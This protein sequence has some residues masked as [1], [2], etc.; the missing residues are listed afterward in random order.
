M[1]SELI[2]AVPAA[3]L[4]GVL[5]GWFWARVLLA[6][7]DLYERIAYSTALS[8]VLVPSVI[9]V[10]TRLF[11]A[12]VSLS[13]ALASPL[14]VF[15][16]GLLA[17]VRFGGA[18]AQQEPI[19]PSADPLRG[20]PAQVLLIAAFA[21]ALGVVIGVVPR[22]AIEP[23]VTVG[24]V[25]NM[26][27]LLAIALLVFFAGI[28]HLI[29]TLR[30]PAPRAEPLERPVESPSLPAVLAR[31]LLLPA[32]LVLALLRG[33][34]GPILHDWPFIR[35]VDHYSHAV[36]AELM[37]TEGRIEPYLIYP[38]GF[39][40]MTAIVCRLTGLEPLEVFPV[41]APLLLLLPALALYALARRVWGWEYGVVAA[42]FSVLMGGT[43]YYYNDAMYPNLVTS[44]FLLVL[45]VAAL[46]GLYTSPPSS[47]RAAV[48]LALLGSS[49]VLYHQVASMYLAALLAVVGVVFVP[50]LLLRDRGKGLA[51]FCALAALGSLSVLY[52][53]ETYDLPQAIAGLLGGS[54][55]GSTGAA[56]KM[57]VG[58]QEP[59]TLDFL[60][61]NMVSQPVAWLG[62]L[63]A[64]LVV[65]ELVRRD[66]AVET[67]QRLTY[68]T[69]LLLTL[70]LFV[71]SRLWLTG[72]PQRFGRDVCVPLAV[73]AAF[74]FVAILRSLPLSGGRVAT[75]FVASLAVI[76][77]CTM[78]GVRAMSSLEFA[79]APSVQ[80]TITPEISAA[81]EWLR[82]HNEGGNIMVS[83]HINQVPSRMMLAMGGYSA[84]QA[85][86]PV[87]IENPRDLPPTGPGPLKDV[88]WVMHHPRG[89]RT[90]GLLRE[91]DVRYIALYK[92]MPDRITVDYWKHFKALPGLYRT[93]FE[94]ED[95]LIVT[96][97]QGRTEG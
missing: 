39:H 36:M 56:V 20:V 2:V 84:L 69:L 93:T 26:R 71:G 67:A 78:V 1:L 35:G 81:G 37:M 47:V 9:L 12:G 21:L 76:L 43:Y 77:T 10:P 41:A 22:V 59:Y 3:L 80:M 79:S 48:L 25:P 7:T 72:F 11:G 92:N 51:L 58:T 53:W 29:E 83:P 49:T 17:H 68:L 85:F 62:L 24:V 42:F 97:R 32:V 19:A 33:Y 52:A 65:G 34:T 13:V 5:P 8:M 60:L 88:L 4:V 73:L 31:R 75:V 82:A 94:N 89:E 90:E 18:K 23:P 95:V 16:G 14:V 50:Y 96:R 28:V 87:Q 57:A 55:G 54:G 27:V 63:G 74:A 40:T 15:L 86:E 64:L 38:P 70:L 44:Q 6:S 30:E 91:H 45:A 66:R 46:V 61:G